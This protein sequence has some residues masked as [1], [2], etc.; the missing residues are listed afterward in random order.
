MEKSPHQPVLV[1]TLRPIYIDVVSIQSQVIYGRVGNS[2]AVPALQAQG[3]EVAAV[4][5]VIF[6]NTPHYSTI[7]GGPL[8]MEWFSGYLKD[9]IARE[10]LRKLRAILVGYLGSV[11]QAES[12]GEWIYSLTSRAASPLVVI[13][14]VIGDIDHGIYVDPGLVEA[15]RRHLLPLASGLTPNHFEL[16]ILTRHRLHR[17][18][19]VI[20]AARNLLKGNTEWAVVTSAAPTALMNEEMQ[21]AVVTR[22]DA[23]IL[24]H[25]RIAASPKG[26]GDLFSALLTAQVLAGLSIFE[27]AQSACDHVVE[28]IRHTH[29]ENCAE[30]LLPIHSNEHNHTHSI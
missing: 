29:Q 17:V 3:L 1:E 27:A 19:D 2:V 15:Y 28:S 14:P 8:P 18:E 9:L 22:D 26:T 13:D 10:A 7:H 12:L 21:V 23:Q 30:L 5:T 25:P 16:E 24:K 4:P 11:A 20:E 6:S